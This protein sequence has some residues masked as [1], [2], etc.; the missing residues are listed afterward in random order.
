[1]RLFVYVVCVDVISLSLSL[2]LSHLL[3]R[4]HLRLG[5][6]CFGQMSQLAVIEVLVQPV[7]AVIQAL[8]CFRLLLMRLRLPL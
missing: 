7:L 8:L 3:C 4:L 5:V 2:S 6:R 1:M